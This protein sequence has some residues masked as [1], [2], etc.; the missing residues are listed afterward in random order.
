MYTGSWDTGLDGQ[1]G[2]TR[3]R[4]VLLTLVLIS[5]VNSWIFRPSPFSNG[6]V[7]MVGPG[8]PD[9]DVVTEASIQF[10]PL[11][12][13]PLFDAASCGIYNVQKS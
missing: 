4:L 12:P 6:N 11:P 10:C 7:G 3:T 2:E 5:V 1:I 13:C 8:P 9:P